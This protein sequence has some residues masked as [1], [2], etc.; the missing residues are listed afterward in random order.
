MAVKKYNEAVRD[1]LAEE[2][3]RD[4][5]VFIMGEDIAEQ[6]GIFGC[7]QGLLQ[8]FG[9][10]RVRNTPIS[11]AAVVGAG[12]GASLAGMRPVVELMYFDF[13][14][15][16]MDQLLNQAAKIRYMYGGRAT[17]P[18]VI[19]GQQ[20]TGKVHPYGFRC[21]GITCFQTVDKSLNS[22]SHIDSEWKPPSHVQF[23]SFSV[24]GNRSAIRSPF[25]IGPRFPFRQAASSNTRTASGTRSRLRTDTGTGARV[26]LPRATGTAYRLRGV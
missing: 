11:E 1:V 16:A 14:F 9:S 7:T 17:L 2:M 15:L 20:G 26:C 5:R 10:E 3:R 4:P 22:A 18:L 21:G 13:A 24:C 19:R 23:Q 12:V 25:D 6:G 8:E